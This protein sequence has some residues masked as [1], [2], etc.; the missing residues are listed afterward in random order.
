VALTIGQWAI[1][2]GT[3]P[4]FTIPPGWCSVTFYST[5]ASLY[6]GTGASLSASNGYAVTTYPSSFQAYAGSKGAQIYGLNSAGSST[7][8]VNY[9]ISTES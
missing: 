6:L 8:P 7:S 9:I 4:V 1:P 5:A 3:I 2:S